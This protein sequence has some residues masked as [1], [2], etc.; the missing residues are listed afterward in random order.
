MNKY[1]AVMELLNHSMPA[2]AAENTPICTE[3]LSEEAL[4]YIEAVRKVAYDQGYFEGYTKG[5]EEMKTRIEKE[6]EE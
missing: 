5:V 1:K 4:E 2:T 3:I 6:V